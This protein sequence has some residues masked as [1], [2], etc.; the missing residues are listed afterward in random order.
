MAGMAEPGDCCWSMFLILSVYY[1][2][3]V[4]TEIFGF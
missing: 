3:Q 1:V 4:G 2:D